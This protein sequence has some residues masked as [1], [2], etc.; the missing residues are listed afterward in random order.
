MH[1][2]SVSITLL[3]IILNLFLP[4]ESFPKCTW[5]FHIIFCHST[6]ML[7]LVI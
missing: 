2:F 7:Y 5:E 4:F 6:T 3:S 1:A